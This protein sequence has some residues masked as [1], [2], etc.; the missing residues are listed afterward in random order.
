MLRNKSRKADKNKLF[1]R[2]VSLVLAILMLAGMAYYTI[3]MLLI[4]VNA[5]ETSSV[6]I[7]NTSSLKQSGDVLVSVGLSYSSGI[8]TSFQTTTDEGYVVGM[9][10]LGG[11]KDFKE[12]WNLYRT[13]ITCASDAN[14]SEYNYAYHI[15][16]NSYEAAVGGYH[17][18]I[19]CDM[20]N[21]AEVNNLISQYQQE[22]WNLGLY[23]IP[24]YIYTGYALRIGDFPTWNEAEEYLDDVIDIFYGEIVSIVS[25]SKTAVSIIDPDSD[26]ILFEYDCGGSTE[27]GLQAMENSDGNTYITTPAGN[28]YDGVFCFKRY[29]NG[30]TDGVSLINVI[31]LEAYVAGVLPFEIPHTWPIE[32]LKS[33]AIT[34]RSFT[35]THLNKHKNEGFDLCNTSSC[36]VYKG[37]GRITQG[38]YDAVVGTAGQV[39]TYNSEIVTAYYSSSTGG[40]TVSSKDAWGGISSIP[41]LQAVE[42]PWEKYMEHDNAF[43]YFEVSPR[44]LCRRLNDAGFTSLKGEIVD[45]SIAEFAENSTYVKKLNV[46]DQYGT[47]VTITN[48]D[49]IRTSLTPYVNSANFVVGQGS[50]EYTEMVDVSDNNP[51]SGDEDIVTPPDEDSGED[52][53]NP[54]DDTESYGKD[55][56]YL[57]LDNYFVQSYDDVHNRDENDSVYILTGYGQVEHNKNDVFVI[58]KENAAAYGKNNLT[59]YAA[60]ESEAMLLNTA[61]VSKAS[62]STRASSKIVYKTKYASDQDNFIFVGKGWGHG[63]GMSQY[64]AKDLAELGYTAEQILTSY[65]LGTKIIHYTDTTNFN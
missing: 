27:L 53:E 14:L 26:L 33:F 57:I 1:V 41:Y 20:Y 56:G 61:T 65:F 4:S 47:T 5:E 28:V 29:N 8:T 35:L 13:K 7:R 62:N 39:I 15:S 50:V 36:Q 3:Y 10:N 54:P 22:V 42:T 19:D 16:N 12:L 32:T 49:R 52:T 21:R 63:V 48:T 30:T 44:D 25:P 58:T 46:T 31:P 40:V 43:W 64:G 9:Q 18:Q 2:I 11:S 17:I 45:V 51:D 55:Y 59:L 6:P 23:I 38:V 24:S 60:E 34:V 37:A